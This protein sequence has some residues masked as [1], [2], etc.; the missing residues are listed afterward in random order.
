[1]TRPAPALILPFAAAAACA[2]AER[3]AEPRECALDI[4]FGSYAM[5]IDRVA[6]EAVDRLLAGDRGVRSV[7]RHG[8][9]REGEYALCVQTTSE[10]DETRLFEAIRKVLPAAPRGP[11]SLRAGSRSYSAPK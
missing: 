2:A 4:R 1:M 7:A 8:F 5:G 9:G 10:H 6:A 11:I 3:P